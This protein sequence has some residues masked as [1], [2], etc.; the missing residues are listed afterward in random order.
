MVHLERAVTAARRLDRVE[1]HELVTVFSD[2]GRTL[3]LLGEYQRADDAYRDAALASTGDPLVRARMAHRR[4]HLRSEYLGRPS[5]AIRQLRAGRAELGERGSDAA[6]LRALLIA[7]EA[8]VRERQGRLDEALACARVAV[9]EAEGASDARALA[10]SLDVLNTCL[11]RTGHSEQAEHMGRVLELYEELGDEVQVA[12]AL[13]NIAAVA[14]FASEWDKAAEYVARSADASTMAGD[15][16]G[17]AMS[18]VNLG[19]LRVNQGRLD[20][21]MALL[22][23]ARRELESYGYRMMT[24]V[25]AMQLGRA[26]VFLGDLDGGVAMVSD[27][28]DTFDEIGSHVESLEAR[29]RLA[30]VLTFGGR[31]GPARRALA[32]AREFERDVG[33]TAVTALVDRIDLMIS[34]AEGEGASVRARLSGFLERA[35]RLG[36]LYEVL[37]IESALVQMGLGAM[38]SEVIGSSGSVTD[39]R[40]LARS[41]GVVTLPMLTPA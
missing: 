27:A 6:G 33:E 10:L 5:A 19:E 25:A 15:L 37:V 13:G 20:E 8:N 36:A 38:K 40:R 28:A 29:A 23:P 12:I 14:F 39:P 3:E 41:L 17:A 16:A 18:R 30:E 32:Q 4:A 35:Q 1:G 7:E 24:A 26:M 22:G 34:A 9:A 2:L 21:A 11:I 31:L